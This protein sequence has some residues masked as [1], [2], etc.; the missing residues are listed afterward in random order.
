MFLSLRTE[1]PT[2]AC[3]EGGTD[4]DPREVGEVAGAIPQCGEAT[5]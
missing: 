4:G 3:I 5:Y 1:T 2:G